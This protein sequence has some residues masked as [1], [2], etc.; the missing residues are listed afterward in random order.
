MGRDRRDHSCGFCQPEIEQLCPGGGKHDV[1]GLQV[2][3]HNA[4]AVS[5]FQRLAHLHAALQSLLERQ[6]A[7]FQSGFECLSLHVLHH[8]IGGSILVADV[9]QGTDVCVI[10]RRDDAGLTLKALLGLRI[11]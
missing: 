4:C 9:V 7:F 5:F 2:A 10:Q 8:Q 11:G 3:M 1:A 6:W